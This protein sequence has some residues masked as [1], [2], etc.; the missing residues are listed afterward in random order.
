[1]VTMVTL[2][3]VPIQLHPFEQYPK[4]ISCDYQTVTNYTYTFNKDYK[5]VYIIV[6]KGD[7]DNN[8]DNA[9]TTTSSGW[10]NLGAKITLSQANYLTNIKSLEEYYNIDIH[11]NVDTYMYGFILTKDNVVEGESI[12]ITT[13]HARK[14][15]YLIFDAGTGKGLSLLD[16]IF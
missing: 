5:K 13:S 16:L 15:H 11:T 9:C 1:M 4:L 10:R 7:S 8:N 2:R 6:Y 14:N 12:T 3:M